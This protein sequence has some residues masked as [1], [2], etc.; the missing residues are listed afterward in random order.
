MEQEELSGRGEECTRGRE[1]MESKREREGNG[2]IMRG[3]ER[4][5]KRGEEET[6]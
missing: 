4:D 2:K 6:E 5:N 1:E 3:E